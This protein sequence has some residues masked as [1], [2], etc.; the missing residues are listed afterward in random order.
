M[1]HYVQRMVAKLGEA[2]VLTHTLPYEARYR[3]RRG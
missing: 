3:A 2:D 1:K